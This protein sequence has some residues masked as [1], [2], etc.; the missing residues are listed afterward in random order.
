MI[1]P[2]FGSGVCL[3]LDMA[4]ACVS[5]RDTNRDA[6]CR[7]L[8]PPGQPESE[9][10]RA[11][12]PMLTVG[13]QIVRVAR[14]SSRIN[15]K[16][17]PIDD[18][19]V[20]RAALREPGLL[21]ARWARAKRPPAGRPRQRRCRDWERPRQ[22]SRPTVSIPGLSNTSRPR[23]VSAARTRGA[24]VSKVRVGLICPPL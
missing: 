22:L 19:A 24:R 23:T 15:G 5:A 1:M 13:E 12:S 4:R 3:I 18:L 11:R 16:S 2:L 9:R 8:Q 21:T 7:Y 20:A 14:D 17:D 6:K 10:L